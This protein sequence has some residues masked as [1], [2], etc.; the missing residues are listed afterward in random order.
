MKS[1]EVSSRKSKNGRRKFKIIL[2]E[3]YPDS[4]INTV[5]QMGE[6]YNENGVTW[7]REY[8]E[9]ALPTVK[10]MSLRVEFESEFDRVDILGHGETGM[11][12]GLPLFEDASV[13]GHFTNAYIDEITDDADGEVKTVLIGEGYLDEM[14]YPGLVAKLIEDTENGNA[15]YG[16]VEIIKTGDNDAIIYKYGYK[17]RGRIPVEFEY[18]GYALLG[19][20][21]A[22]K[23][24]KLLEINEFLKEGNQ[25]DEAQVKTL[26]KEVINEVLASAHEI[27]TIKEECEAKVAAAGEAVAEKDKQLEELNTQLDS[28]K[29]ELEESKA[30]VEELKAAN[31]NMQT[32]YD[33]LKETMTEVEKEKKIGELE[34]AIGGFSD[35]EKAYAQNDIDDFLEHPLDSEIISIIGKI[36][37]GIGKKAKEV[38][39][40]TAEQNA[41]QSQVEDIFSEIAETSEE[42]DTNIF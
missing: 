32:D 17:E 23:T 39:E 13:V 7:I 5:S 19:V 40:K 15:P 11:K 35:D 12:N 34:K 4:C 21:P 26:V 20:R 9:K 8:C 28:V 31:E 3:I 16:S 18:S 30:S 2:H 22:D 24:A 1:F 37:E 25:M 14:C 27:E 6:I 10:D 38:A 36:Y 41:A 33:A 29:S 42:E